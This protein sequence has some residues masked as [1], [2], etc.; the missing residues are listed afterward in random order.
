MTT[1]FPTA[2]DYVNTYFVHVPLTKIRGEP[3]YDSLKELKEE[4]MT[5]AQEVTTTL[6]GGSHGYLG[7]VVNPTEYSLSST[8]PYVNPVQPVLT[9]ARNESISTA[10]RTKATYDEELRLFRET[11]DVQKALK[12][13]LQQSIDSKYIKP[14]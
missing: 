2:I 5:N 8:T 3:N 10:A 11:N 14:L 13:Q 9:V 6:G 7:L 12:K 1:T 4:L